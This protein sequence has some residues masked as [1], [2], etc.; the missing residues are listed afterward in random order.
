M[1]NSTIQI[2]PQGRNDK[3]FYDRFLH[4]IKMTGS[5]CHVEW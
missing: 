2:S 3:E 5:Y 1:N 4:K